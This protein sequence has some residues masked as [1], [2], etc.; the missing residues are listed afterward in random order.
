[1]R[2]KRFVAEHRGGLLTIENHRKL[3]RWARECAGHLL[4]LIEENMDVR[5]A[6][7][8]EVAK[9]WEKGNATT[10]KAIK[11]SIGAHA[12]ARESS[13]P[14]WIAVARSTA[15]AVAT[16]HMAD[17]APGGA[18]YAL[19]AVKLSGK[20]ADEEREWQN[21]QLQQLPP[22]IRVLVRTALSKKENGLKV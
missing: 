21:M 19:K 17:H 3:I 2:D 8:I 22:E 15:Y 20:S 16:A 9:E 11:A 14:V 1:M 10:G 6:D 12:A 5:L 7:A 18:L 13:D 4:P